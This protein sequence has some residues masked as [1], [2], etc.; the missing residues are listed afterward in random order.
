MRNKKVVYFLV[1]EVDFRENNSFYKRVIIKTESSSKVLSVKK[2]KGS[3]SK[4]YTCN[5][6]VVIENN[7]KNNLL[8]LY[9][10]DKVKT[11]YLK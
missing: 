3:G 11:V 2:L 4:V 6:Y 10:L 8:S 7:N 5:G 9:D 1:E